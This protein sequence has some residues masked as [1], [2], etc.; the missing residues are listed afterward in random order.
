MVD[1]TAELG[2]L[3]KLAEGDPT[4]R[5]D[6]LYR[7]LRQGELL[8]LAKERIAKNKGAQTPGVDGR[9]MS[10]IGNED[11]VQLS[12]ELAKG[13]Y[14]PM[15]V[16]R[17]YVPKKNGRLRPLGIPTSLDKVVQSGVALILEAIYEPIF[18]KC[19]HG[20]RPERSTITALRQVSTAYRAGAKWIIEG[21]ITDCFGSLPHSVILNCLRKR[22]K[23]E[24]FIDLIRKMLQA[25]V[26]EEGKFKPTYSGAPQ[27]GIASPILANVV[28]HE[29]DTWLEDQ[30]GVN[31]PPEIAQQRNARSNPEYMR[32][33]YRIMDIRRMLNG[34][35]PMPK[36]ADPE[37]LRQERLEKL[38]LRNLQPRLL[39]RRVTY[40][41][42]YADDFAIFLCD[43]SKKDA[44]QMKT[45]VAEWMKINLGLTLNQE[46]THVTHWREK[47][48]FLGYELEGRPNPNG[49]GW[50]HLAVPKDAVRNVVEKIR[51]ATRY[52]QA[53]E[54]D[55]FANI[56]AVARGWTNYY[57]YAHNNNVIGGKLSMVIF[58]RTVHYLG[59]RH[60][61]SLAK[62]MHDHYTRDSK[63]GCKGLFTYKPGM[64]QIPEN[65][66]FIWHKMPK[67]LGLMAVAAK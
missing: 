52:P 29:L 61:H 15:P 66:Y 38:R 26:M 24:R 48:R 13:T 50:L 2:H 1:V 19:S 42:R 45:A 65:R 28:L 5:F 21:D 54:Y 17:G 20:F 30:M 40:Y 60:R 10:D 57:R 49:N 22:I 55:V 11:L 41:T 18:R 44:E 33:H 14:Q 58:W 7:L 6:R 4:K 34:K 32:L 25:G 51:Q 8:A 12:Q 47:V 67:R 36:N 37:S 46:K 9:T 35:L 59:K 16:R 39:P 53:P 43:A 64:P 3:K 62:V 31:P 23:D 56:N 27:G 63:T